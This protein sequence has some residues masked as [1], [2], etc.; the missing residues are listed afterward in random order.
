MERIKLFTIGFTRKSAEQF[1]TLLAKADVRRVI[2]IRLNNVSQLAGFAKRDDL[3]YFLKTICDIDYIHMPELAPTK[4]IL[5]SFKKSGGSWEDYRRDFVQLIAQRQIEKHLSRELVHLGCLLCS[6]E[7]PAHCH[8]SLVAQY[9][10]DKWG[11][12][13]IVHLI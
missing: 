4:E 2:D 3:R 1:F 10:L 13:D 8:R 12:V 6:E 5:D 9:L 11:G 7:T